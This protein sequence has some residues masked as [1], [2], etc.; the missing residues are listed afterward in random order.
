MPRAYWKGY[1]RLPLVT[2]P[3]ELFPATSES[4][5]AYFHQINTRTGHRL[6]QQ[7]VDE[8]TGRPWTQNIKGAAIVKYGKYVDIDEDEPKAILI[9]STH[10]LEIDGFVSRSQ[11]DKRYLDTPYYIAP[12]GKTMQDE[13]RVTLARIVIAHLEHSTMLDPLGE[14]ILGTT[15]CYDYEVRNEK[16]YF[17]HVP[18][19][20]ISKDMVELGLTE[21][22]PEKFKGEYEKV[23]S[24]LV[25]RKVKGHHQSDGG[26]TRKHKGRQRGPPRHPPGAEEQDA[27]AKS[28]LVP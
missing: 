9:E 21:I 24:N 16:D 10:T 2:R 28:S 14:G 27:E 22:D 18:S 5:K 11:I 4:E 8:E 23:L 7:M 3:I 13:H 17:A 25:Q 1:L 6:R 26:V 12:N 15:L 20:R 19:L